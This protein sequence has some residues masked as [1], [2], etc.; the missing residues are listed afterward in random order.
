MPSFTRPSLTGV[1]NP[2]RSLATRLVYEVGSGR[3]LDNASQEAEQL[4][5]TRRRIDAVGRRVARAD[6]VTRRVA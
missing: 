6:A 5:Q 1:V 2:L 3:A 4:D